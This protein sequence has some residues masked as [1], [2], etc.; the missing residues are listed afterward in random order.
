MLSEIS[1]KTVYTQ[2]LTLYLHC[3]FNSANLN[4]LHGAGKSSLVEYTG[5]MKL[6]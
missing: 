2:I 5:A 3:S 1:S 6:K 4:G